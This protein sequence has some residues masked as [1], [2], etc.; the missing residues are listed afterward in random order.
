MQFVCRFTTFLVTILV[1]V[2]VHAIEVKNP[3]C[4]LMDNPL[5][6]ATTQPR[7]G[8]QL[9]SKNNNER[10]ISYQI[11]VSSTLEKANRNEG[12]IWESG[13]EK[14]FKSQ[15][16][17]YEGKELKGGKQYFWK[18]RVKDSRER[19]SKWS[20]VA[21]FSI[22]PDS[23][24]LNA[25]WIGAIRKEDSYIPQGRDFHQPDFKK[26]GYDTLWSKVPDLA[27]RSIMLRKSFYTGESPIKN[28]TVY[29]SGLGHYELSINGRKV[30]GSEF[31][32]LWSDYDK[33]VYYNTYDVTSMV[34]LEENAIGVI[35]GNGFYNAFHTPGR[36][37]KL[38]VSFGPPTL[39]LKMR[40]EYANGTVR[41]FGTDRTWKYAESP[42]VFNSIFGGEDYDAN[43]E[44]YGWNRPNFDDA[45]WKPVVIQEA[46]KGVLR[47]QQAPPVKIMAEFGINSIAEPKPGTYVLDMGQNLSGFPTLVVRGKKG[48]K[49]RLYPGE[50]LGKDSLIAQGRT[51]RPYYFEYT[52][53]GDGIEEWTP[54]FSYYGYKYIQ[55]DSV[56]VQEAKEGSDR[57]LV[58][59]VK[60]N[61]V[62]N[63]TETV[64]SFECSNDM[65][66]KTH[67]IINNAI[68]SNM[69]AVFTDCPHREKLGWL[70]QVHLNGPGLFY[71]YNMT[72][73]IP[74]TLQDID[75]AQWNNGLVPSIT[76]EYI[77]FT[78]YMDFSDSPEWGSAS[79]V[80]PWMY[81]EYYG[82]STY[83]VKYFDVMKRY[84]DYLSSRADS[85]IVSHGLGDWYDYG[86]HPAG[87]SRNSP[88]AISATSHYYLV[89]ML[90]EKAAKMVG[91]ESDQKKYGELRE[92]IRKAYNKKFFN[93]ETKQYATGSQFSNAVSLYL[94]LVEPQYKNAVMDNLIA[95]I[96]NRGYRLTT[97]D[98]GNRYLFQELARNGKNEVMYKMHNHYDIPGYGFQVK[99]G[100][101]TLTE[102]WDPRRG[103]SGN[104]FM[105]GQIEEWF[106]R[107]LGGIKADDNY[108]GFQRFVISPVFVG[109]MTYAKASYRSLYGDIRVDWKKDDKL[110]TLKISIPVNTSVH[111]VLPVDKKST[112]TVNNV[113]ARKN[114]EVKY[115]KKYDEDNPTYLIGSGEYV[116]TATINN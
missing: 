77:T 104:H 61:F 13:E 10:Q 75:D 101:T 88:I 116:F 21:S 103:N 92:N 40:V 94:G 7:F 6:I 2:H 55:I 98:I 45:G 60:S 114:K 44:Q 11:I 66:N 34:T 42:I 95:D 105:L 43:L 62:Y 106:Y 87:Y 97:G 73:L 53:S 69:H 115:L 110:F 80:S 59:D 67:W 47:P 82:D 19:P 72:Q 30:G 49:V 112:I 32:P 107:T 33:T 46:P 39:F 27:R 41:E 85:F 28:A 96:V 20:D 9:I 48:Q 50:T 100:Q 99:Y 90:T 14:S 38:L 4:E 16:V 91:V 71:N 89:T 26:K 113:S 12:D 22:A 17:K 35:L 18:V 8:W 51:G 36:Y 23:S 1:S 52:L 93:P 70:E 102:Q 74:K 31:A 78:A 86:E 37:S 108:P 109:D 65:F 3:T 83:I 68:K 57:P 111:V 15:L 29:V 54:R 79:V 84:V 64:G 63:S 76:P 25:E 81:Y 5:S 24:Y 58:L 56:D